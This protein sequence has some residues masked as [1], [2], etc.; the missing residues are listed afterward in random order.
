[1]SRGLDRDDE[2]AEEKLDTR[3]RMNLSQGRGGGG[4]DTEDDRA[5]RAPRDARTRREKLP[6]TDLRDRVRYGRHRDKRSF[7]G[8]A[9]IR[10]VGGRRTRDGSVLM[11]H[12]FLDRFP[13]FT[14][15]GAKE[16]DFCYVDSVFETSGPF[17]T[18]LR[19]YLP[20]FAEL[21]SFD[22]VFSATASTRLGQAQTVLERVLSRGRKWLTK[23][24]DPDRS[25]AHFRDRQLFEKWETGDFDRSGSMRCATTGT[26]FLGDIL[27]A[28]SRAG[29]PRATR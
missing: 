16:L 21:P 7:T 25:L 27:P 10:E 28:C 19:Q 23:V 15:P 26:V 3:S 11:R 4:G 8:H 20:L 12:C 13:L 9:V 17:A 2:Q 18:H 5:D 29:R 22:L 1:V 14:R 6:L 24:A